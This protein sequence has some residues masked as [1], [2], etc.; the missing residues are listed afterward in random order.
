MD[1]TLE[2]PSI[3][4]TIDL[5]YK[6][7]A[8]R[9]LAAW[10]D[11]FATDA[12]VHDPV[13]SPAA[14]GREAITK[15]WK[16]FTGPFSSYQRRPERVLQSR[17]GA[18]VYWTGTASAE[19]SETDCEGIDVFEFNDDGKIRALMSWWDPAGLLLELAGG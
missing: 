18:A 10:L 3:T 13:D 5:L 4:R 8:S 11:L 2:D 17:G 14:E 12:V 6:A 15:L 7:Q 19:S 16:Q 1:T 9:D